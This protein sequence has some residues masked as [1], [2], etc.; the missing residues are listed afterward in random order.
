VGD[1]REGTLS[2]LTPEGSFEILKNNVVRAI[3]SYFPYEGKQRK[4]ELHKVW[5][6][7]K[8]HTDDIKSQTEAKDLDKTWGV[9]V[10]ADVSLVDKTTGK[11]ID[12]KTMTISRL[13]KMTNRYG[14][15]VDGSE[16]QIDHLF[17]L[18][19]GVYARIQDNGDLESEFNLVKGPAG[20]RFSIL[21]ER[22][23]K[24]FFL[25]Q[26]DA[27]IPLYPILKSLGVSDDEIEKSWGRE[28]LA[29]NR[30]KIEEKTLKS[31]QTF[32]K[33]TAFEDQPE[34]KDLGGYARYA[35][36]FFDKTVLRPDTTKITLGKPATKVDG[37][38]LLTAANKILGVSRGTHQPDDRDSL[39]FKEIVSIEDFLPEK[40]E[41][42]MKTIRGKLRNTI[43]LKDKKS[44]SEVLSTD[45]FARPIREFFTKGG[46]LTERPDQT[47][48]IQMMSGHRKTT[49]M[50]PD[51]G[52]IK[53]EH[54]I[55]DEMRVINPSHFG[56]LDPMHTPECSP[57]DTEVYTRRGWVRWDSVTLDDEFLCLPDG[58][59]GNARFYKAERLV[60][61]P[62]RGLMYGMDN[63]KIAYL[64]TPNHRVLARP[65]SKPGES[66]FRIEPAE[67]VHGKPRL[68]PV[69]HK[70]RID[71]DDSANRFF[72]LPIVK[73]D[74]KTQN[75]EKVDMVLW[76]EFMG[77]FLSE[78][79]ATFKPP[80]RCKVSISQSRKSNPEKYERIR[81]L[82]SK[83]PFGRWGEER[84]GSGFYIGKKQLASYLS[85]FGYCYDKRVPDYIFDSSVEAREKFIEA[86][87]LGDG[88][89]YSKRKNGKSYHQKVFTTTSAA[90]ASD[91][92]RLAIEMGYSVTPPAA[93]EDTRDTRYRTVYE[94]R[95]LKH[96]ERSAL[97]VSHIRKGRGKSDFV[98]QYYTE[99]YDGMVYSATVPGGLLFIRRPNRLGLWTGNSEKT[100]ITL[101]LGMAARK[102]GKDLETP[103]F[104]VKENKVQYLEATDFHNSHAVLPDQVR[105]VG[106][107]PVPIAE[108]VKMKLPGGSIEIRPFREAQYVMPSAKGM[109]D[110]ASN[111]IPFLPSNQGNRVSMADKQME[112]AISLKH[113]DEPLV[114]TKTDHAD[115]NLTFEKVLGGFTS[116][117]APVSGKVV[118]VKSDSITI[119]DGKKK[120]QVHL[121]DHFPL[122]DP[123]G[124]MHSEPVVKVGDTVRQGQ[125]IA[126]N[127]FT[128]NG[129][130]SLGVNL[131]VGYIPYKGYNYE[132]G[133]VISESAAKKLTSEHLYKKKIELDPENDVVSKSKFVAYAATKSNQLTKEQLDLLDD[134]GII[135][136]GSKVRPGQVLI[137]AVGKNLATRQGSALAALGKRAFQ[138]YKDKSL[139]WDEDH[140][141]EVVKVIKDPSGKGAKVYVKTEEPLVVGDKL[142]GRHG[143]KGIVT[144]ILPD[145]E[146]PFTKD[147]D[148][149]QR[150]LEVLLNPTGVPTR[151][152][153]GQVLETA[154]GKIA[155]KTGKPYI[156]NNFSGPNTNYR[157]QVLKDL[158][159]HGLSDEELV[160]DP[161]DPKKPLG[162]VLVGPQHLLKLKH[163]VEKKLTVRGGGTDIT[164]R[165]LP[166]DID[167]TPTKGGERG[168]QGFGALDVY[169]LLGHD[170]RHNLR[171]M[172]T[173]KS[174]FQDMTFWNMVQEGHEPPP[175]K[176]PF[177][178]EKFVGLLKG[179]GVNVEKKGTALQLS[180]LT[181]R[182]VIEMAGG[183]KGELKNPHLAL[184]A[185]DLKEERGGLFDPIAT[186]GLVGDKWSYIK[187]TEPMPNPIFVGSNNRPG[188]VPALLGLK[189][190]DLDEVIKGTRQLD[191]KTGGRAIYDALKKVDVDKELAALREK[192]PTLT[193]ADLDRAN[194]KFKY[195]SALK[196][197]GLK[198]H[199]AYVMSV[200]PVLPPVFRPA[201][202][203]HNGD[204]QYSSLNGLYK[205]ISILNNKLNE[206]DPKVFSEEHRAP[207]RW[208][209]YD[210]LKALQ[211]VGGSVGY[212]IDSPGSKRKLK[213]ILDIIGGGEGEQPKEGYFQSKLVKRR[214]N[215]SIRSTIVPE[216]KLGIDEV[217]IPKGAAM[218]LY[219]PFVV[220]ELAHHGFDPLSA[221]QEMKNGTKAA[222]DALE[223]VIKD[224]PLL[225]K[226]DPALH[227]FSIM[228][229]T[230]RLVEGKAIQI[231]PLVTG[232]YNADF[233][234]DTMAGTVPLTREAVEEA[235]KMFPSK[236]LFSPTTGGVMYAP[237]Q[238]SMLGLHLLSKWGKR[239]G[240]TFSNP[241]ELNKA[242]QRGEVH[243]TDV[244]KVGGKETTFGRLLLESR[245]PRDFH[246]NK[247]IL[248]NPSF[249]IDKKTLNSQIITPL[250]K[251]HTREF[252]SVVDDLKDLGNEYA[253]KMGFSFGLKDLE[254]IPHRD[255]ILKDAHREAEAARRSIKDKDALNTK[256]V[257]IYQKATDKLE[258]AAKQVPSDNRLAA[259]VISGA[260]GKVEQLRQMIAA[261]MLVQDSQNNIIPTPITKSYAEGLDIGDYWL[262]QH[263]ARKG[264]LQRVLGTSEP[265]VV[266][267]DII[268]TTMSTLI[269][270]PDCKTNHGL[271]MDITHK[272]IVDRFTSK[273]YKLKDGTTIKAGTLL[274]PEILN[275]LK[276]S[277]IDKVLVR[278]PL[279]C[280]HGDGICAKCFGL[281]ESGKLH[282]V[283]TNIGVLSGQALSEPAVQMAMD[284]FHTGG[285]ATGR[286]S[287][288]VDRLT[289]LR[290]AL[291]MPKKLKNSATLARVSGKV[292]DIKKDAVGGVDIFIG[293]ERHYVPKHLVLPD[294]KIGTEVKKGMPI[295]EGFINPHHL[296]PLTDIHTV[297]NFLTNEMYSGLYEK[298]GVRKRNVEVAVR[299][300]TN[301]TKIKDPGSSTFIHG[302]VA[303]TSIV[304]E[305]NRNLPKGKKPVVHEPI[306]RG[307]S[308]VP[309]T[310]STDWMAR[311]NYREL[312][313]TIQQ[314]AA[315]SWKSDIHGR[316]PIPGLA[317]GAEFG[318]PPPGK[319]K[320][321]Y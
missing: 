140:V 121:Y 60:A 85:Q 223:K 58:L 319:A 217:G 249:V 43:D 72:Y 12:R 231:H 2:T 48:P 28:I 211:S 269:T 33:K 233:D 107:K 44:V 100:G 241:L 298:E 290:N 263:G 38:V 127:N 49:L 89:T 235:K 20:N 21:L 304:E 79:S 226:R 271:L 97:P 192:L 31:L 196:D 16:Y 155:E 149:K 3:S 278:S 279:K 317:F 270:S 268:N 138:P 98:H 222:Y 109:F 118:S 172:A 64:V 83:L 203:T 24:K 251:T 257:E 126:D 39:A 137:A 62:Y 238:D 205:N 301:L 164:G 245:M 82:L 193:G 110:I 134:D 168:G 234:G 11:V 184:R 117:R 111:L 318:K 314:A 104:N 285:V 128:K 189:L 302:D 115:P 101:H 170:A 88:R 167:R 90:M 123:K 13:P 29:A 52:G 40:I 119:S 99:Q 173:H 224:R 186:G 96:K 307:I 162:S 310:G 313:S 209:L 242:V 150:H 30:P 183:A 135:R 221:Q 171:E 71:S 178:Y 95:L 50:A 293:G 93:Y 153:V 131:R 108:N 45:L 236:N 66:E 65:Y 53:K 67:K 320:G 7:D 197:S 77:W 151:I 19:S 32:W 291:N 274:T 163:Q 22:E 161:K 296:L 206:V 195:L 5:V 289:R 177:S 202:V 306:L 258:A 305:F 191:G 70:P 143:N 259:M 240:K 129:T 247:D 8:L 262:A 114:Q 132:D 181:D 74:S 147:A 55:T 61:V 200:V 14:F 57:G 35:H 42:S 37:S 87:L 152:N 124:M 299:A 212:D 75:V 280:Q 219:K 229:F 250:A 106:G 102:N 73:G 311:L 303:P 144:M 276:N 282:D 136:V 215:L 254:T 176:P 130:L 63:G 294:I 142:S 266:S 159:S 113:R 198:P 59:S 174:D 190:K 264:T 273:P 300:L 194:K 255:V 47:N 141:G 18:K 244:V 216:P 103:V 295:S 86:M 253:F 260:R 54:S 288:S 210:S 180:P 17:R 157:E 94:V 267:K 187:L 297:Q 81:N 239:I 69:A 27:K 265:G 156:V 321:A 286:G 36:D 51:L 120:H 10:K 275:R 122:N 76:A 185:K 228:A 1:T 207:L 208:Q 112:Q 246:L 34:P 237:T 201:T 227:K 105:W 154:A 213:G 125:V 133:I 261:P 56:F 165:G 23:S 281:N 218:E 91:F 68:F 214:Q 188:P 220:A 4:L 25:K 252:A 175:P 166:Y 9:P 116:H 182:H 169:T 309:L 230:P 287:L 277:K 6:D 158:R 232:G 199:E 80:T 315:Q 256:L 15:I 243:P 283:G 78:G 284:A 139:V 316:H 160:Y 145:H 248:H 92:Y 272:D 46:S 292:T 26:G 225:L 148:G 84:D 146:M 179:L 41:R 308:Q 204:V 312:H